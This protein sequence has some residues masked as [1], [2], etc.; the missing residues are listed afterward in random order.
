MEVILKM[1]IFDG[2]PFEYDQR[3]ITRWPIDSLN[4]EILEML[5]VS[6]IEQSFVKLKRG[7]NPRNDDFSDL[8]FDYYQRLITI[9]QIY[10]KIIIPC[11]FLT[12]VWF[13]VYIQVKC[14]NNKG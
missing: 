1:T 8:P 11:K 10:C 14:K 9:Q 4:G 12:I 3:L 2:L 13:L 7:S 6:S 5:K